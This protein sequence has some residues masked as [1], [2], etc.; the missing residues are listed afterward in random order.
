MLVDYSGIPHA[1]IAGMPKELAKR[2]NF[3]QFR[4]GFTT[5]SIKDD[6]DLEKYGTLRPKYVPGGVVLEPTVFSIL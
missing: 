5:D 1:T 2:L 4:I 3:D 6:V